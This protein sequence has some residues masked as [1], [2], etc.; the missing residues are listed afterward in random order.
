MPFDP[1]Q[2]LYEDNHLI[3]INKQSGQLSDQDDSAQ[4]TLAD[5]V[6][7]YIKEKYGKPGDVFLGIPHRLDR[8]TSG[9]IIYARTSKALE[10]LTAM[11]REKELKKTYWCLVEKRPNPEKG[12][13]KNHLFR[14]LDKKMTKVTDNP[15]KDSKE[16]ILHYQLKLS[17]AGLHLLEI[18]LETGRHHQIRAQLSHIGS[19]IV[20]DVKYGYP[21]SNADGSICLHAR[22]VEFIHPVKKEPTVITAP[23][24]NNNLWRPF[25]DNG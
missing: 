4:S 13:L 15:T 14:L 18:Q 12:T 9:A 2:I 8:P 6:K 23:V 25:K 17:R 3:V 22:M 21:T 19:P 20:G 10:R 24:P 7:A 5:L 16:A 11:L 1:S